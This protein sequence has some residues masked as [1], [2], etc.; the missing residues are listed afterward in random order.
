MRPSSRLLPALLGLLGAMT[1]PAAAPA[2][3]AS[4]WTAGL[5]ARARLLAGGEREGAR[6]AAVEIAPDRGFKTY[7]RHPG[8]S[9]LTPAFDWAGSTNLRGAEILWP[10]PRRFED[11]G[12]VSY[13]YEN[14]VV[15]PL[16]VTPEEA[17]RPVRLTLKLDYGVCK[18]IC[19]PVTARLSLM[20]PATAGL[21]SPAIDRALRQVPER[22]AMGA[23][24]DLAVLSAE[25]RGG[26]KP[27][28]AVT[29]RAPPGAAPQLFA[30]GPEGWFLSTPADAPG[31]SPDGGT[32]TVPV[33]VEERPAAPSGPV[34]IRLTVTAGGRAIEVNARPDAAVLAP[35]QPKLDGV[36][37]PR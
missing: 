11:A 9:G 6:W 29:L 7:W 32:V 3:D 33:L 13:G 12:G 24:G 18:E 21:P 1:D 34:S 23:P 20:L 17:S 22:R 16:R 5:H 19:I 31:S 4:P 10:A 36:S 14:G 25:P 26:G 37:A 15:L 27:G 35:A 8:E 2:G 28:I 30:E